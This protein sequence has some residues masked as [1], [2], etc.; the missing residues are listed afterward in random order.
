MV[1]AIQVQFEIDFYETKKNNKNFC[2]KGQADPLWAYPLIM[3]VQSHML[4]M[5]QHLY[6]DHGIP[7][8]TIMVDRSTIIDVFD[9]QQGT[10]ISLIN[11]INLLTVTIFKCVRDVN[12]D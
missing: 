10:Q 11:Q 2:N 7:T 1:Q 5:M 6:V 3:L 8:I 4:L 12:D 9:A